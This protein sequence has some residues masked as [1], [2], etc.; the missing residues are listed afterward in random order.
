M[1]STL[2]LSRYH[3]ALRFLREGRRDWALVLVGELLHSH[4]GRPLAL[5]LLA[6]MYRP[7]PLAQASGEGRELPAAGFTAAL[8]TLDRG[9]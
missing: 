8:A 9:V 5:E 6:E 1:P 7:V 4:S 3:V 2:E